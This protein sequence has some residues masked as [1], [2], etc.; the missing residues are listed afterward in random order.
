MASSTSRN[1]IGYLWA[2]V[3]VL[4]CPCHLPLILGALAGST[5]GALLSRHWLLGLL[6]L[7]ALFLL[8]AAQA[9]RSLSGDSCGPSCDAALEPPPRDRPTGS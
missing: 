6:G 7:I 4:V 3:A 9:W 2:G 5:V 8:S 1:R